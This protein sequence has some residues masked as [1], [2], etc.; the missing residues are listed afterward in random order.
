MC[1]LVRSATLALRSEEIT[2]R[3]RERFART[4]D[5]CPFR[6][7]EVGELRRWSPNSGTRSRRR[8]GPSLRW[9]TVA[10]WRATPSEFHV[11]C[12]VAWPRPGERLQAGRPRGDVLAGERGADRVG[13]QVERFARGV[14]SRPRPQLAE[15]GE[16]RAGAPS[17]GLQPAQL[18]GDLVDLEQAVDQVGRLRALRA[19]AL[20]PGDAGGCGRRPVALGRLTQDAHLIEHQ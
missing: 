6:P 8:T 20:G 10:T 19:D 18:F 2:R 15:V 17:L 1:G 13:Q 4:D 3:Y 5:L 11:G 14:V 9:P 7:F 12:P 16:Q